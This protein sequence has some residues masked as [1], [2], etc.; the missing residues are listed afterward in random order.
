MNCLIIWLIYDKHVIPLGDNI[1]W[2]QVIKHFSYQLIAEDCKWSIRFVLFFYSRRYID[3][4]LTTVHKIMEVKT[5]TYIYRRT[6]SRTYRCTYRRT[7][8]NCYIEL[9]LWSSDV[10]LLL[11]GVLYC[12]K[13][14]HY[15][16]YCY[17]PS[18]AFSYWL[19]YYLFGKIGNIIPQGKNKLKKCYDIVILKAKHFTCVTLSCH[20][21]FKCW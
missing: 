13:S 6:Y 14:A 21:K 2:Y 17:I 1:K 15:V 7:Y 5:G 19:L 16:R 3:V 11:T 9:F 20:C 10:I 18:A 4:N 12:K 8:R